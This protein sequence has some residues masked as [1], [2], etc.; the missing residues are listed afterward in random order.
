MLLFRIIHLPT[1]IRID[2]LRE[3]KGKSIKETRY[4]LSDEP[5]MRASYYQSL[6]RGHWS[7]ENQ[8]H[9]HLDVTF[10]EDACKATLDINYLRRLLDFWCGC[11]D[12]YSF[13]CVFYFF[14]ITL[15]PVFKTSSRIRFPIY[16]DLIEKDSN[17]ELF[18]VGI[19]AGGK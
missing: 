13:F 6:V 5:E 8:L 7:L 17:F 19:Y 10:K 3:I 4:Y 12:F 2:T 14:W 16:I 9:W 11:P 18:N 15:H 1:I